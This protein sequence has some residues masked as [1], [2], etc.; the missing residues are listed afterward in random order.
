VQKHDDR[1]NKILYYLRPGSVA[2]PLRQEHTGGTHTAC[3]ATAR[4][5]SFVMLQGVLLHEFQ[6]IA[7]FL[8]NLLSSHVNVLLDCYRLGTGRQV[9]GVP[10]TWKLH[11]GEATPDLIILLH[12]AARGNCVYLEHLVA[13]A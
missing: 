8:N 9:Q 7:C 4:S 3:M 13:V 10:R 11:L 1:W 12:I 5:R 2:G 6:Y